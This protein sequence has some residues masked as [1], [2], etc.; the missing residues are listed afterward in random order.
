MVAVPR[1]YIIAQFRGSSE[2]IIQS[3]RVLSEIA[4]DKDL[5]GHM[6]KKAVENV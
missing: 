1:S 4:G 3:V 6:R 2:C 5:I